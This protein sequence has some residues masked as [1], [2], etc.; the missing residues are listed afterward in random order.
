MGD[1]LLD[2]LEQLV[3]G[4]IISPGQGLLK[5]KCV[6]RAVALEHQSTQAQQRSAVERR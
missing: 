4:R 3:V 1:A 6:R 5:R 2:L